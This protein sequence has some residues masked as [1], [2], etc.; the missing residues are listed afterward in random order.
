MS[1]IL[2]ISRIKLVAF[3]IIWSLLVISITSWYHMYTLSPLPQANTP[4]YIKNIR[5][6]GNATDLELEIHREYLLLIMSQ[7]KTPLD[8]YPKYKERISQEEFLKYFEG[9]EAQQQ[10]TKIKTTPTFSDI[11]LMLLLFAP[12][13]WMGVLRYH[14]RS[15]SNS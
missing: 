14:R 5:S 7:N 11:F 3:F 13:M 6:D 9:Y 15:S 4:T 2:H 1:F 10:I 8:I 12:P